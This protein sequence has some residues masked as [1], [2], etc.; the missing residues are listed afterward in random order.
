MN[1]QSLNTM[2]R[3]MWRASLAYVTKTTER[4]WTTAGIGLGLGVA[5]I[6]VPPLGIAAFGGAIAGWWIVVIIVAVFGGF[7][8]NRWG[9][10]LERRKA[11]AKVK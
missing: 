10:E 5:F 8:G 11:R 3:R 2:S 1:L 6:L 7:A 9:I 4:K